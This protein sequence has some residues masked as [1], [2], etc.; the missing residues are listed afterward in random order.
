MYLKFQKIV[1]FLPKENKQNDTRKLGGEGYG[2]YLDCSNTRVYICPNP[3]NCSSGGGEG[4]YF[5]T[6][7]LPQ[8]M[9]E[10]KKVKGSCKC[11]ERKD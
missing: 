1:V 3:P 10:G 8:K 2:Y 9:G 4:F 7:I 6:L 11:L 5:C